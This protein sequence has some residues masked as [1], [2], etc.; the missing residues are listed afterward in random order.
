LQ[1]I[2]LAYATRRPPQ[3]N[4]GFDEQRPR[5]IIV[6]DVLCAAV[7]LPGAGST[8]HAGVKAKLLRRA[9]VLAGILGG[10]FFLISIGLNTW[11]SLGYLHQLGWSSRVQ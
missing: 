10:P 9:G 2:D 3:R 4:G 5:T 6:D 1:A 7:A 8:V 11:A